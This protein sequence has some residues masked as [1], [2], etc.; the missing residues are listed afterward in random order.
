M[1]A[2]RSPSTAVGRPGQTNHS[3]LTGAAENAEITV[4]GLKRGRDSIVSAIFFP[5]A[6][7]PIPKDVTSKVTIAKDGKVK[8]AETTTNGAVLLVW[9]HVR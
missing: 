9:T 1:A 6:A 5:K 7:E 2:D 4:T 3:L 8:I